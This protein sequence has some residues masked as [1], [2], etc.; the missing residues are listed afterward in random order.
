MIENIKSTTQESIVVEPTAA[1][2]TPP[3]ARAGFGQVMKKSAMVLLGAA[4]GVASVLPA[5]G[6]LT[7][8]ISGGA[9]SAASTSLPGGGPSAGA[10]P[11]AYTGSSQVDQ[12]KMLQQQGIDSSME[13]LKLQQA[14]SQENRVFS[15]V[16][17]VMKARHETARTA[18]NNIR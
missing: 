8:A 6:I 7:A 14:I 1:R 5:G 15:T 17:N 12:M 4:S 13:V 3:D 11:G 2:Q 16:S 10:L 9:Q 18:I